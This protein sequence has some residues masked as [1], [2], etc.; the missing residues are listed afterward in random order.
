MK[1]IALIVAG[2][3]GTRMG[4]EIPKQFLTLKEKP[5][6]Y[7]SVKKFLDAYKDMQVILVMHPDFLIRGQEIID[8]YF[9]KDRIKITAGGETRFHSVKNGLSLIEEECIIFV[10]D[11][12]RCLV[13]VDLIRR[14]YEKA[15]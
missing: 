13:S 15:I 8:A 6:L 14:S 3:S 2:G 7:Y 12:V 10:H 11:A 4:T 9:E 1:K 5:L